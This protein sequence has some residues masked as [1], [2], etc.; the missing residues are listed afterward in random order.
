MQAVAKETQKA[1]NKA[2]RYIP[3]KG[4]IRAGDGKAIVLQKEVKQANQEAGK[5]EREA[6]K[7]LQIGN[8]KKGK[9][10]AIP[11]QAVEEGEDKEVEFILESNKPR[12]RRRAIPKK[13]TESIRKDVE[14]RLILEELGDHEE[15]REPGDTRPAFAFGDPLPPHPFDTVD[16][17][18]I[19]PFLLQEDWI[20]I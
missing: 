7:A 2:R 11:K 8:K 14:N 3:W 18:P 10:K 17:P 4:P 5:A 15:V 6:K 9:R 1:A 19:D 12:K 20:G 16:A 13:E